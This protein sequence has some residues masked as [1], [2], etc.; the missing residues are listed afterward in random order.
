VSDKKIKAGDTPGGQGSTRTSETADIASASFF[1]AET[2]E[3]VAETAPSA[4]TPAPKKFRKARAHKSATSARRHLTTSQ[5]AEAVALWRTGSV[6]LGD[7]SKR[8]GKRPETFSAL[9]K[10]MGVKK[11]SAAEEHTARVAAAVE[12]KILTDVEE[13]AR[14]VAQAKE[15][16]YK[17]S[18]GLAKLVWA[19]IVRARQAELKI[20]GLKETMQTLRLAAEVISN[21]RKELWTVLK[22]EDADKNKELEDLPELQVRE[23]TDNEIGQLQ[24][25][26]DVDELGGDDDVGGDMLPEESA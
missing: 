22:I 2:A 3:G 24:K 23:L 7:L 19:E 25:Q 21:S 11:G 26:G 5:K 17:M 15:D 14:R 8:F 1:H 9:F 4:A 16:H 20:E 18:N 12:T 6:T 13:H 10:R